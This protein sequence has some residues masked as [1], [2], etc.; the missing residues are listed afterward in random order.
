MTPYFLLLGLP[1]FF[2]LFN[3]KKK[4]EKKASV[5][6]LDIFFLILL[7]LLSLRSV[8]CGIDLSNYHYYFV[9]VKGV[10][11]F[12]LFSVYL[13]P[14]YFLLAKLT[15]IISE[16]FQV[17]LAVTSMITVIPIWM[18][19]R[20]E[21]SNAYLTVILFAT[22]APFTMYF[23]GLRQILAMTLAVPAYYFTKK[24][25]LFSFLL[26]I[27]VA[28][29]FHQSSLLLLLLYPIYHVKLTK[30]AF[31]FVVPAMLAVLYFNS[32]IFSLT[33]RFLGD[34]YVE[35]YQAMTSTGAYTVLILLFLL[36]FYAFLIPDPE[37]M[38]ADTAGLR[39]ILLVC[40]VIQCFAPIH[41]I[42]MRMNYYFLIFIP[43]LIPKLNAVAKSSYRQLASMSA[44]AM[45][46]VFTAWF[47]W[48][49][50]MGGDALNIFP[51]IPV[52]S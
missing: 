51:Y 18:M 11:F 21:S 23:S 43:I 42:A 9:Q 15:Q 10:G 6:A 37:K 13:E 29:F 33:M 48:N 44:V 38:D 17:F 46:L 52:W 24:K 12:D 22:V 39:N 49:A 28:Y 25:K 41:T 1:A 30:N 19:Y 31:F 14:G 40:V 35:R 27:A 16:N 34:R 2:S 7:V 45:N 26:I 4:A 32:D 8:Q 3:E 47:F 36:A 20:K 50:Y 5:F